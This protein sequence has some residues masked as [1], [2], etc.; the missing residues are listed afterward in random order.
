MNTCR[1]GDFSQFRP[2]HHIGAPCCGL[3]EAPHGYGTPYEG[4]NPTPARGGHSAGGAEKEGISGT[5]SFSSL[6]PQHLEDRVNQIIHIYLIDSNKFHFLLNIYI[7]I[8]LFIILNSREKKQRPEV[9]FQS[10]ERVLSMLYRPE[11]L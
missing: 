8:C 5:S 6:A 11:I 7:Y 10:E 1:K 3:A 2:W 9:C 4:S